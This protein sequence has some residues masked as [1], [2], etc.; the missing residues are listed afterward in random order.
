MSLAPSPAPARPLRPPGRLHYAW[1]VA[2][3]TFVVLMAGAGIR[4]TPSILLVPLEQEFGWSRATTASAVSLGLLLYGLAGPFCA[5][6]AQRFGIRRTMSVA[7]LVLAC[8][9]S[10]ATQ[11]RQPWQL[12]LLWGLFVGTGT[13]MVAAVMGSVVV[14]RWF[15][16]Q[17][18]L[19]LGALTASTATGQL[20]FLPILA[21]LVEAQGWRAALL[22]IGGAALLTAPLAWAFVRERPQD[23][24][25]VRYGAD[26]GE[27]PAV[28][29]AGN[30]A[31]IAVETLLRAAR[32]RDF[33][34]LAGTFFVCGASTNGLI[35]THLI[36]ACM[37]HGIPE[38]RAAGILAMMGIFDLVG[39]TGS[40]WLS[41]RLDN[42]WLLFTYYGLRGLSLVFLPNALVEQG[43][44]LN[45]FT[46]FYGLDWIATVPPTVRLATDAFGKEDAPIV[47]GWVMASHQ[48]GA[49]MA[50]LG[51]G[52]IRTTTHS[53]ELAFV[54]SGMM[55]LVAA[56]LALAIGRKRAARPAALANP[57]QVT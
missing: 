22:F 17:R 30:P 13:G 50:A 8:A 9:V 16:K 37:D 44:S 21:R 47:F 28:V 6:V 32:R 19:V 3:T 12:V 45:V 34:L 4:A 43:S 29:A 31:R 27:A 7:M 24:G 46:V 52:I 40:G 15:A 2:G 57:A 38:V 49:G 53:Y 54:S 51:A 20:L 23:V 5:A 26:A 1:I 33:W 35:G 41:D 11:V 14:N 55:C 18:G 48:M 42:R 56:L 25:L 39:T 36:P 10:L